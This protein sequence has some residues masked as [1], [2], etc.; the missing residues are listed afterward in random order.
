MPLLN[1][2]GIRVKSHGFSL[3]RAKESKESRRI[4]I[5]A[6]V[7]D[8]GLARMTVRR[9]LSPEE[10]DVSGSPLGAAATVAHFLGVSLSDLLSVEVG[11]EVTV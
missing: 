11:E 7:K 5:E 4:P 1:A 9:F 2:Q 6:V 3:L 10:I 8:T